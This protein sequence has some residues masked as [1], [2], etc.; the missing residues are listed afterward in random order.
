MDVSDQSGGT[1][2]VAPNTSTSSS[3]CSQ[4]KTESQQQ[5]IL[6]GE[7]VLMILQ[8]KSFALYQ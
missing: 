4:S 6:S 7:S 2:V 8:T 5:K 3:L 1:P